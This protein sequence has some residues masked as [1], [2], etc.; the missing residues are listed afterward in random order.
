MALNIEPIG[1]SLSLGEGPHWDA[2]TQSLYFVDITG[3][4]V[5]RYVPSTKQYTKAAVGKPVIF[6]AIT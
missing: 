2:E 5:H 6:N 4:T 3:K 1:E